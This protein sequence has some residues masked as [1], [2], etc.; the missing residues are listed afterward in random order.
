[1]HD[2]A[3]AWNAGFIRQVCNRRVLL[4]DKSGVP[5]T[6]LRCARCSTAEEGCPRQNR[7][8]HHAWMR[9]EQTRISLEAK[10]C[11]ARGKNPLAQQSPLTYVVAS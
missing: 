5:L 2:A 11:Q 1:M 10:N 3:S 6:V 8:F 7:G 4:P 9:P